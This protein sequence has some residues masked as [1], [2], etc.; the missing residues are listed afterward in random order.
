MIVR[1]DDLGLVMA[2]AVGGAAFCVMTMIILGVTP[3]AAQRTLTLDAAALSTLLAGFGGAFVGGLISW[4]L[5]RQTAREA[6]TRDAA[7]RVEKQRAVAIGTLV[8]AGIMT[9]SFYTL[10]EHMEMQIRGAQLRGTLGE[11]DLLWQA[12]QGAVGEIPTVSF[13]ASDF[14]PFGANLELLNDGLELSARLRTA[15]K[16]LARYYE[17]RETFGAFAEPFTIIGP[18][19]RFGTQFPPDEAKRAK[20]KIAQLESL[21]RDIKQSVS[22]SLMRA[23]ALTVAIAEAGKQSF[24]NHGGFPTIGPVEDP[25]NPPVAR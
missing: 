10:H 18:D 4:L 21:I 17:L 23:K 8:K 3:D 24:A 20:Q 15:E 19:G 13:E 6:R 5:A 22:D 2:G 9:N 16:A 7:D 14:L 12:V 25:L 11:G 1:G